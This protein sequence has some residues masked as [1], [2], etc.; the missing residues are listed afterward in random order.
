MTENGMNTVNQPS[1]ISQGSLSYVAVVA[2][3]AALGGLLFGYDT[4][5]ISGAIG[6][7]R[8]RFELNSMMTGWAASAA[9]VGCI[10]GAMFAGT[11]SDRFGRK[12]V[13]MLAG[14]MFFISAMWSAM[15]YQL[16]DFI[17]ARIVGG[18]G[19]GAASMLSPLYIAEISPARIRGRLVSLNQFAIIGG[20][21]VVYFVN[22]M[23]ARQGGE[24]WNVE[25]GWRWMFGSEAVPAI[26]FFGLLFLVP[27]SPRWLTEAGK[28]KK[29]RN[30]LTKV[31]GSEHAEAELKEI[32]DTIAMESGSIWDLFKPGI[33]MALIIGAGLAILQQITGINIVLYYAPEI[34]KNAGLT[35]ESALSDTVIVGIVNLTFTVVAI[36]VVDK[37][38]RK[39]LLLIASA[40]MGISLLL[41]GRAIRMEQ[42][43]GPWVLLFVLTYV[44]SFA[45]AM[46]PVVWVVISEIFP[47]KI[48]GR[49]MSVATVCLWT[50]CFLV[51]V[52]FPY[53]L[54][55]FKGSVF[56]IYAGV[57]GAAFLFVLFFVPE[58]KGKSLEEIAKSWL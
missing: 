25:Y 3:V 26:L 47:T 20:M 10:F 37:L 53:M 22:T 46:G 8:T 39:P 52:F 34:F 4:A 57:C 49:A 11:L 36:A 50:A 18:L 38:G 51:S 17:I 40:G 12:R 6:F 28:E 45:V 5:V 54:E 32:K 35:A 19:V 2:A 21:L 15:P 27:E 56:W 13:M 9:L 41:L 42:F 55:T 43:E 16:F 1:A 33:R 29:A 48:R 23:I 24:A 31:G 14:G 30:I 58:T 7:L 44:A